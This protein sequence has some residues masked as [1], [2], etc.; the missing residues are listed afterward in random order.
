MSE[1]QQ[2]PLII[3]GERCEPAS[4]TYADVINPATGEV[5]AR[6]AMGDK[7]DV[8]K[9]VASARAAFDDTAWREMSPADRSKLL[10]SCAH[11]VMQNAQELIALEIA[12]SGATLNRASNLDIPAVA[13]LWMNLAE[14]VKTYPFVTTQSPRALPEQW[15]SQIF[16]EPVGVCGLITAWNFPLLLFSWK[17]G[18]ALAAGN[19][20][21][22]KPSELTP[23]SSIRLAELLQQVL[24][25]GVL[26]VVN[27]DG[28]HVGDAMTLHQDIDK[29][30]FTGSTRVGRIVQTNCAS[31][32]KRCTLELGGKGPGIVLPDADLDM[33]AQGSL[34]AVYMNAGQACESGTRLIVHEDV[35]EDL[36]QKLADRSG[37]VI[38]GNPADPATGIGPMSTEAHFHRV[39]GYIQS[40]LDEGARLVC[41]GQAA[42][43]DGC[44]GGF[45]IEPTVL[46]DVTN[47]MKV[48]R[49]EI[50]GPVLSVIRYRNLED[51]IA[52]AN[53]TEY[54]LS[55]GI[56]TGD[57]VRAQQLSRQLRA[58]SVWVN[59]WHMMRTDAPFGGY[60]QSGYG[61]EL[62]AQSI[63]AYVETK[64]VQ[65]SFERIPERKAMQRIVHTTLGQ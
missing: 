59:D 54:G 38:V 41:G 43:V 47:D 7:P 50:F 2:F 4:G 21:V 37:Q 55:A 14:A 35:Y 25:P 9:A 19:T 16:K 65:M 31:T 42:S 40:G 29:I 33:V 17:V 46:A 64:A 8:D 57:L 22:L 30:S 12:C 62:G 10:Y 51:A 49:E 1:V 44:E 26:N 3:N 53:D 34:W 60:K 6:A 15:H 28:A 61:R 36:L 52:L 48:A 58:G 56:W 5:T 20:I 32:M 63:D 24:P 18:P 39:M 23:T 27:G 13:D 45:Y 11:V